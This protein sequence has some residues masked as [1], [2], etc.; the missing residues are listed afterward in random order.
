MAG[1]KANPHHQ[2]LSGEVR[3]ASSYSADLS[4]NSSAVIAVTLVADLSDAMAVLRTAALLARSFRTTLSVDV[5]GMKDFVISPADDPQQAS[6]EKMLDP[7]RAHLRE[8]VSSGTQAFVLEASLT[9]AS[10]L[11]VGSIVLRVHT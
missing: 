10:F 9:A 4:P 8:T 1:E 11:T 5:L 6:V 7:I 2:V 3:S